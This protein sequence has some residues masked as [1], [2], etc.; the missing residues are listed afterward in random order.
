MVPYCD[1]FFQKRML[2]ATMTERCNFI[3]KYENAR[4]YPKFIL[5]LAFFRFDN[6]AEVDFSAHILVAS[7]LSKK[8]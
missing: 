6:S 1:R 4:M 5:S 7:Q 8:I 3:K 2:L